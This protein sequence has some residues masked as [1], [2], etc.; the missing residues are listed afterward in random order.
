MTDY[1]DIVKLLPRLSH[2]QLRVVKMR[3]D[4]AMSLA[5]SGRINDDKRENNSDDIMALE[6][7]SSVLKSKGMEFGATAILRKSPVFGMFKT[8]KVPAVTAYLERAG[9]DRNETRA[10]IQ[11]GLELLI[12]DLGRM[13]LLISG[14]ALM[15][16]FHRI[17]SLLNQAF[18]GYAEAGF[19]TQVLRR[20]RVHDSALMDQTDL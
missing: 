11:I 2:E 1:D 4:A 17:P 15:S 16:H 19:L 20:R 6:C 3:T 13:G 18:P 7:I 12:A 14:R 5:K 8:D 10:M 9:F